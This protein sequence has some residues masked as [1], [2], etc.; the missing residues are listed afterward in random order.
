MGVIH[1]NSWLFVALLRSARTIHGSNGRND[2]SQVADEQACLERHLRETY[3]SIERVVNPSKVLVG[4]PRFDAGCGM[5]CKLAIQQEAELRNP[6][7]QKHR[8]S[9]ERVYWTEARTKVEHR[10]EGCVEEG[11]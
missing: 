9:Y 4:T 8:R 6:H 1:I 5:L 10:I 11:Y 3:P 7:H 2:V